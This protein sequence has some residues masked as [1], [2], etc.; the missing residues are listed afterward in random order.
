MQDHAGIPAG[1]RRQANA[2]SNTSLGKPARH[3]R[4]AS[5]QCV[6]AWREETGAAPVHGVYS[7]CGI[8][9]ASGAVLHF[10]P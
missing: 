6:P 10:L 5:T 7:G 1:M 3:H 9:S 4:V 2:G 8:A